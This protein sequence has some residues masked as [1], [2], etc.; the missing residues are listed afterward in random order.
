MAS[1]ASTSVDTL[2]VPGITNVLVIWGGT[3]DMANNGVSAASTYVAARQLVGWKVVV[4]P[5]LSRSTDDSVQQ[6]FNALLTGGSV[7]WD[8]FAT[9]PATLIG[10]GAYADTTYFQAGGIHPSQL[11][12]TSIIAPA[13]SV[14]INSLSNPGAGGA[15]PWL[16]NQ[17]SQ[18]DAPKRRRGL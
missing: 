9:L 6:A 7:F 18:F 2:Y 12:A 16:M 1:I 8:A 10:P 5:N 14:A 17:N 4:V 15:A 11:S 13:I 3:N